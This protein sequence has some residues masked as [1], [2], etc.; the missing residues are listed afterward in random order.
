M[1]RHFPRCEDGLAGK[2][3]ARR[4]TY[5]LFR[6]SSLPS[7]ARPVPEMLTPLRSKSHSPA[8]QDFLSPLPSNATSPKS[9]QSSSFLLNIQKSPTQ[10]HRISKSSNG[11]K[12]TEYENLC[13]DKCNQVFLDEES[14][15][16]HKIYKC[17]KCEFNSCQLHLFE[18]HICHIETAMEKTTKTSPS[19]PKKTAKTTKKSCEISEIKAHQCYICNSIFK[20]KYSL[21]T[22]FEKKHSG[23][24]YDHS[25]V[26]GI[27]FK[28]PDCVMAFR[29]YSELEKHFAVQHNQDAHRYL[30]PKT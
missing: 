29:I 14:I 1:S 10:N 8:V 24:K 30:D 2:K 27:P 26:K 19:K 23:D 17:T 13:C 25:K 20:V 16:G 15:I 6:P 3:A 7:L 18:A 5:C 21:K 22:H 4:T 11:L 12:N 28:C 9:F